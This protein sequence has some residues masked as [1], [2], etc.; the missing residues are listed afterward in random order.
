SISVQ[1]VITT[2]LATL[3]LLW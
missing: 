1:D 2:V 3:T